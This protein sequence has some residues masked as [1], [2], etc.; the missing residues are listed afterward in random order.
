M[1]VA[2][3]LYTGPLYIKYNMVLRGARRELSNPYVRQ[4]IANVCH[5]N[6]YPTTLHHLSLGI[7]KLA[8]L[9]EAT[10]V[11]RGDCQSRLTQCPQL[12]ARA[13]PSA[14]LASL[15]TLHHWHRW[16][17]C[18]AGIAGQ[19][20]PLTSLVA[21]RAAAP[22]GRLPEAFF[23]PTYG[24][25]SGGIE[26]GLLSAS[27]D[28]GVAKEYVAAEPRHTT[29]TS[30]CALRAQCAAHA[31]ALGVRAARY[32]AG[33]GAPLIFEIHQGMTARGADVGWL[34][35]FPSEREILF[36]PLT[37]LEVSRHASHSAPRPVH[38]QRTTHA[39]ALCA[40]QV[41]R[42]RSDGA[43][44]VCELRPSISSAPEPRTL[45]N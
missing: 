40:P 17:H 14:P 10:P 16:S 41:S 31:A 44:V 8:K 21:A 13:V 19:T 27:L 26:M 34:S 18:T 22:G 37:A 30:Q 43:F 39:A 23:K 42:M 45:I 6:M 15:V 4:Y 7:T 28:K 11:Y 12:P 20:A 36:P 35:Q 3:R 38:G 33:A 1:F 32:A 5:S 2:L 24:G 29:P 9:T 25:S